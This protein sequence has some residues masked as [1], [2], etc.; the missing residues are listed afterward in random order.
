MRPGEG[1]SIL[2]RLRV[3]GEEVDV[4]GNG[5]SV[6]DMGDQRG[7]VAVVTGANS[8]LGLETVA[9]LAG[10]GAQVVMACRDPKRAEAAVAEVRSRVPGADLVVMRLDLASLNQVKEFASEVS[11]KFPRLDLLINNAGVMA[12][13]HRRTEDGFEMQFG[14]NHLGHF[15]LTASLM[16]LLR[17]AKA[18]RVVTVSSSMHRRGWMKWDDL[19]GERRYSK[20][21]AY[22]QSKL[23]NLLFTYELDRRFKARG[24]AVLAAAAHPGY[25]ATNLQTAGPLM[26]GNRFTEWVRLLGNRLLAQSAAGGALPTLYAAT[27]PEVR[28]GDYFGPKGIL[29]WFGPP[30]RVGSNAASRRKE[31]AVRLWEVSKELTGVDFSGL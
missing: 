28:G 29:Q 17:K 20:W 1:V 23:A 2:R 24:E 13:P 27:S 21:F 14:V 26:E 12:L 31:D 4:A 16:D 19:Q 8:G 6:A 7:K 9:G 5:W 10:A 15:A 25:A 18:P 30:V 11:A 22:G 3:C